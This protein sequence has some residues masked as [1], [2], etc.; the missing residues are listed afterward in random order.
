M[1]KF[2]GN[3]LENVEDKDILRKV[4]LS[5]FLFQNIL[6]IIFKIYSFLEIAI[7]IVPELFKI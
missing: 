3:W 2:K 6:Y 7:L 5:F 4:Q 1:P